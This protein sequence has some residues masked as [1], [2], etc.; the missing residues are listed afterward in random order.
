MMLIFLFVTGCHKA[1]IDETYTTYRI[2]KSDLNVNI[3]YPDND[4][5]MSEVFDIKGV[6]YSNLTKIKKVEV[7]IDDE[8]FK[9]AHCNGTNWIIYDIDPRKY[10]MGK[11]FITVRVFDIDNI[12]KYEHS[13]FQIHSNF[14][15][16][17]KTPSFKDIILN[18][19][20]ISI[21]G[22]TDSLY[23][24]VKE[25]RVWIDDNKDN[26]LAIINDKTDD[27]SVDYTPVDLEPGTHI[28]HAEAEDSHQDL[29]GQTNIVS[30]TTM[31]TVPQKL[32]GVKIITPSPNENVTSK[33]NIRGVSHAYYGIASLDIRIDGSS[34]I[35]V[36]G[37][38]MWN[39]E[40]N[41]AGFVNGLHFVEARVVDERGSEERHGILLNLEDIV[42]KIN[43][44]YAKKQINP[45]NMLIEG[46]VVGSRPV[47][48]LEIYMDNLGPF[49][50][51]VN[52][53]GKWSYLGEFKG[54]VGEGY[55]IIKAV[56]IDTAGNKAYD[57]K[58]IRISYAPNIVI[59][60]EG[61]NRIVGLD[62]F[63]ATNSW[64]AFGPI[65]NIG[66]VDTDGNGRIYCTRHWKG[67]YGQHLGEIVRVDNMTGANKVVFESPV[68]TNGLYIE[69]YYKTIFWNSGSCVAALLVENFETA[70][71]P[72]EIYRYSG[73][74][75]GDVVKSRFNNKIYFT[76]M[77]QHSALHSI[78]Q[79]TGNIAHDYF[80]NSYITSD[81]PNIVWDKMAGLAGCGV[82]HSNGNV[83]VTMME[84]RLI[85]KFDHDLDNVLG[86]YI[87]LLPGQNITPQDGLA[88]LDVD[89]MGRIYVADHT[90]HCIIRYDSIDLGSCTNRTT[91]GSEGGG[92]MQFR[93]PHDIKVKGL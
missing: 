33:V 23:K 54:L 28:I 38:S 71:S 90:G 39:W 76:H 55:H 46:T 6:V 21:S 31:F 2:H 50:G 68:K 85:L 58:V 83:Y 34:W 53:A 93:Y 44:P 3:V 25:V 20:T 84:D 92:I 56:G 13:T 66:G 35:P 9:L 42:L 7:S 37:T 51:T 91:F 8:P 78:T 74:Q 10:T 88:G 47:Y 14:Y 30:T 43:N 67:S 52:Y 15:I 70:T 41:T 75:A 49:H 40:W 32:L 48:D 27:W 63:T 16:K 12:V 4:A 36:S 69:N 86:Y 57:Y 26:P 18:D 22:V 89:S 77:R 59:A 1:F 62:D 87:E 11:H 80:N 60:D 82:D 72:D 5:V 73:T 45:F 64:R 19:K 61:N 17:I 24:P 29:S 65:G 79:L 81:L